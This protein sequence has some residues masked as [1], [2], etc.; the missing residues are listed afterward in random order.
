MFDIIIS[1]LK[2]ELSAFGIDCLTNVPAK[3]LSLFRGGGNANLVCYPKNVPELETVYA[4]TR[5]IPISVIANGSNTLIADGGYKGVLV[6]LKRLRGKD[7]GS[8]SVFAYAGEPLNALISE[9]IKQ[10][11]GGLEELSGIPASVG[12]AVYMNA[13][14]FRREIAE[15]ISEVTLFDTIEARTVRLSAAEISHSYRCGGIPPGCIVLSVRLDLLPECADACIRRDAVIARRKELHPTEPSLG[16]TF[17]KTE[18]GIGAGYFIDKAGLK[19]VRIGGASISPKHA[20]FIVNL[21]NGTA[22]DYLALANLAEATV[23]NK[24]G[25]NLVREIKLIGME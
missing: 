20:N 11:L 18:T 15:L 2:E 7:I 23:K 14:A 6:S 25:I 1:N 24:F 19:G 3:R 12:G 17:K 8:G 13:G 16:S 5:G 9:C 10:K 21:A 4:R 22:S